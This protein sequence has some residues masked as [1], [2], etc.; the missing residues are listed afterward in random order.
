LYEYMAAYL[1]LHGYQAGENPITTFI[2]LEALADRK[3]DVEHF[4]EYAWRHRDDSYAG[5]WGDLLY[6]GVVNVLVDLFARNGFFENGVGWKQFSAYQAL[7]KKLNPGDLVVNLNYEPLF[8]RGARQAGCHFAYVPNSPKPT[9]FLVA[10]P[11]GSINLIVEKE[12][13]WFSEPDIIGSLMAPGEHMDEFRGIIPPRYGKSLEQHPIATIMF[14]SIRGCAPESV[15]FWGVGF[16]S[17]DADLTDAYKRWSERAL[18]ISLIHPNPTRVI[19]DAERLLN[20]SVLH[21]RQPEEW[22]F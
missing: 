5:A 16:T 12:T 22:S 13:F 18:K 6:G 9:D 7:A 4:F 14:D 19:H 1:S 3:V 11:H 10:K 20:R 21:F 2:R 15:T 8:E 17:S